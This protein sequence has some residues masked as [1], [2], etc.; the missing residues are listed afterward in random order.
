[1]YLRAAAARAGVVP[2]DLDRDAGA[3]ERGVAGALQLLP[4][5]GRFLLASGL[6]MKQPAEPLVGVSYAV[7]VLV[8]AR[9]RE[10]VAER[11]LGAHR[12]GQ[13]EV[14][15]AGVDL[16]PQILG[17]APQVLF[18]ARECLLAASGLAVG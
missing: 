10:R 16:R 8:C 7:R 9:H 5:C 12:V 4:R 18:D 11:L 2:P 17:E 1:L 14:N 3:G 13:R 6:I 15:V